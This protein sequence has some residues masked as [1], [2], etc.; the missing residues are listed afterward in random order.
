MTDQKLKEAAEKMC[1]GI[2]PNWNSAVHKDI[3]YACFLAGTQWQAEQ[4]RKNPAKCNS[5]HEFYPIT[6]WDCPD[7][8]KERTDR[9][10]QQMKEIVEALEKI[11]AMNLQ[12]AHDKYGDTSKAETWACVITARQALKTYRGSDE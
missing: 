9:L 4:I 11:I 6:L 3:F 1:A 8:V 7:C 5:G 10:R 12:T 2:I